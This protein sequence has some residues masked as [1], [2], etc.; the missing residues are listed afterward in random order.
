M[1]TVNLPGLHLCSRLVKD[2]AAKTSTGR[3]ARRIIVYDVT[4]FEN[5]EESG[6]LISKFNILFSEGI[7]LRKVSFLVFIRL[8]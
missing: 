5:P 3:S 1:K 6:F 4:F 8:Y 7:S 2:T